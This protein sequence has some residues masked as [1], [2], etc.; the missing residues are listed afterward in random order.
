M[1]FDEILASQG[2]SAEQIDTIKG[3]MKQNKVFTAGEENLDVRYNKLKADHEGVNSQLTEA[4]KLI[5]EMKASEGNS[6]ALQAK[7]QE[8]EAKVEQLEAEKKQ[9]ETEAALKVALLEANADD[10]DYLTFKIKEK[11]EITI[12]DDGKIKGIDDTIAALKTQFPNQFKDDNGGEGKILEN[13]LEKGEEK[14]SITPEQFKKMGY[15]ERNKLYNSDP[16]LYA[17]LNDAKE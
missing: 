14:D 9:V 10:V 11:G 1:T 5:E 6:E 17:K 12:G 7:I 4:Q 2:L 15:M 3:E 16:E 8:Y 13:K